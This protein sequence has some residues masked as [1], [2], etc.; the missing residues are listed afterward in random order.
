MET[1]ETASGMLLRVS[2]ES[3]GANHECVLEKV[4]G[5][6]CVLHWGLLRRARTPW[7]VPPREAWPDGSKL[8]GGALQTPFV[9]KD[10]RSAITLR[11]D[12]AWGFS[13]L[14]FCL[15]DP[16]T[17]RWDNNQ[18]RNY[19]IGLPMCGRTQPTAAP[20]T[21][22]RGLV[23]C[24]GLSHE[25]VHGLDEGFELAVL[26]CAS[27]GRADVGLVTDLEGPLHLHWGVAGSNRHEWQ[28]PPPSLRPLG[29]E[30]AD[31]RAVQTP[32]L[33]QGGLRFLR[34]SL[35]GEP[36]PR[37][38]CFVLLQ[39][40]QGRWWKNHG[41]NF[42]VPLQATPVPG[43]LQE[44]AL[45]E[46][47][48][49]IIERETGEN[50]WSLMHRFDLAFEMLDRVPSESQQG[51]A[52]IFV[53]LRFSAIRQ[54]DWQRRYNTKP[55]ELA[56]AQDR[57]TQKLTDRYVSAGAARFILRLIATTVGRGGGEGQRV[58]DGILEIMHRHKIKEVGGHFLEEWH[59]KLHNNT[60]PDDVAICEA[61]LEFLRH[62]GDQNTFYTALQAR[63][64]SRER[65]A[66]YE[67]P[68]RSSP[69]FMANL[70]DGL[71]RDFGE[72]LAVLRS[73]HAATDLGSAMAAGRP[74]L[75]EHHRHL[76]DALWRRRDETGAETWLLETVTNLREALADGLKPGKGKL[77]ELLY[78]DL[79]LEDFLRAVIE[80]SLEKPLSLDALM[81]WT[82]L[83]LRNLC[84]SRPTEELTLGLRHLQRL[85]QQ[86]H[87][88]RDWAL[89]AQ[90]ALE[91]IRR[92]LV[93]LVD[94]DVRLLQPVA[95]YLGSAV[96]AAEW[97][98]RLFGEEVVRGRLEFVVA[99]LL[100]KLDELLRKSAGLGS[101][102]VVSPGRG[103]AGGVVEGLSSLAAVQGRRFE[104]RTV[105]VTDEIGGDEDIPEGVTAVLSK[106]TVDLVSHVAV[107][108]RNAGVLLATCWEPAL[109]AEL[110]SQHGAW[111]RL[112]VA[113]TGDITVRP[114]EPTEEPA[115]S[116][117]RQRPPVS[118]PTSEAWVLSPAAFRAENVGAKALNLQRLSG[119]VPDSIHLP[120]SLALPFGVCERVLND[121]GNRGPANQHQALLGSLARAQRDA[122]PGLLARLRE[123]IG[124]LAAPA[125]LQR[126]LRAA[127]AEAGLPAPEPWSEAWRC[128]TRVW[129]S[130][131]TE[132]AHWSRRAYGFPDADLFM[133]VLIQQVVAAEYAFVV[134]TAN[135]M[136]G[137]R[138]ELYA[139]MVPGLGA[140]LVGNHP[141][142]S[143]G[144]LLR[145]GETV[146]RFVSFPSKSMGL[147]GQG[148]IFR[149][150]SNGEDLAGFAGA[151]LY[152][153]FTL[154]PSRASR[155]DYASDALLW[156]D[157]LRNRILLEV[158][159]IGVT[160]EVVLGGPQDIEGAYARG[161]FFVVQARPQV[162]LEHA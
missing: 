152:D 58:R 124:E 7:R 132:R 39:K 87:E 122:V 29:S 149:S 20:L 67:R 36:Q 47:A 150:D 114:G 120:A 13:S 21:L 135:P 118:R 25:A 146:P 40:E 4:G 145:R 89:H 86:P 83:V 79:A 130:K 38:L 156:D 72:F 127:M 68:I 148:L 104:T 117:P 153:S 88:G 139:E 66:G 56:H 57:F 94:G 143:L 22:A 23:Q 162:G 77:R 52:L 53:W 78:L 17:G 144:F 73:V 106:S 111:V 18:G 85:R 55:R 3:D 76:L 97:S 82:E 30:E 90:A 123:V 71:L 108:A 14:E 110:R 128:V 158:G 5:Q 100:R 102:Q 140:T 35:Y 34:L 2:A 50:S 64:V 136:T 92:E 113:A 48:E 105:L 101:W 33:D 138:D 28:L 44:P 51:L 60:T 41:R 70:R 154:P 19:R 109:L 27:D 45:L 133:A 26:V 157:V 96:A 131:W 119:R 42:Y 81:G 95:D 84:V 31:D 6:A 151:G 115:V 1:I 137:D 65:L 32:F 126:D 160:I 147:Y 8:V 80:R 142:R 54:L 15:V 121:R 75:D 63:G 24:G 62:S 37:A 125:E 112:R 16:A 155:I 10:G 99:A 69:E 74:A 61:Y 43:P 129:A 107:R 161:Q 12:P 93:A 159:Q 141:G 59:Q 134:H 9:A 116:R 11:L 49:E 98:I 91:R 46:M 103:Q